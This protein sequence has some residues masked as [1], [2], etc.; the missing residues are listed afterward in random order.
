MIGHYIHFVERG[1]GLQSP[2]KT[3][4]VVSN[5]DIF[6]H[7]THDSNVCTVGQAFSVQRKTNQAVACL[8]HQLFKFATLV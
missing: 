3:R 8:R 1:L 7:L 2:F 6:I 5:Q 4:N